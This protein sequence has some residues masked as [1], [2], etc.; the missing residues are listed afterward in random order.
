MYPNKEKRDLRRATLSEISNALF[1]QQHEIKKKF[2][3]INDEI[4]A[5]N[6]IDELEKNV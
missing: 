2:E 6:I 1:Q 5:L 3:A 4:K